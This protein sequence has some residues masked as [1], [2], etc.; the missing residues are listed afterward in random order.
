VWAQVV[1]A[2]TA[3]ERTV[4]CGGCQ[5]AGEGKNVEVECGAGQRAAVNHLVGSTSQEAFLLV[6]ESSR[7]GSQV[8][9]A[10]PV[11]ALAK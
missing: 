5:R 6:V 7:S 3:L 11:R 2:F 4:G 1:K 10:S 8:A 9:V